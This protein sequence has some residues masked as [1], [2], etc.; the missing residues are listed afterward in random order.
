[1]KMED[2]VVISTD[3]HIC[4]PPNLFDNQDW[5]LQPDPTL[6]RM[7][8]TLEEWKFLANLNREQ[9]IESWIMTS[10]GDGQQ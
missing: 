5:I 1:M 10:V 2:M 3:D 4:E 7:S 6:Y 8:A 9:R